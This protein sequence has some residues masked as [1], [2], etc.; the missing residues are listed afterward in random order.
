LDENKTDLAT[1][2]KHASTRLENLNQLESNVRRQ[3][4]ENKQLVANHD[5]L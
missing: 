2:T 4:A 1:I 3:Q 5:V